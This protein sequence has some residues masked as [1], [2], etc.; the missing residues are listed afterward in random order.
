M[1]GIHTEL[2]GSSIE[3]WRRDQ[4]PEASAPLLSGCGVGSDL[5]IRGTDRW[6]SGDEGDVGSL[7]LQ[8]CRKPPR[9]CTSGQAVPSPAGSTDRTT[10]RDPAGCCV[11]LCPED[12]AGA[13]TSKSINPPQRRVSPSECTATA[14][15]DNAWSPRSSSL[16]AQRS[17]CPSIS[18][19]PLPTRF[20]LHPTGFGQSLALSRCSCCSSCSCHGAGAP[21]APPSAPRGLIHNISPSCRRKRGWD[22]TNP[23]NQHPPAS[24]QLSPSRGERTRRRQSH[25]LLS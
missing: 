19:P 21:P 2:G 8:L 6:R 22:P 5:W 9:G 24:S 4:I 15:A 20:Q 17:Q 13:G 12:Q 1:N 7:P 3:P 25:P 16:P 23:P 11:G 10:A 14:S 18:A